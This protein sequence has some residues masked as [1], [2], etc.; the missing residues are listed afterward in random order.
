MQT[1]TAKPRRRQSVSVARPVSANPSPCFRSL[2]AASAAPHYTDGGRE[3]ERLPGAV[4]PQVTCRI[5]QH[6]QTYIRE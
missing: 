6:Y 2:G 5:R 1:G 4:T 3:N